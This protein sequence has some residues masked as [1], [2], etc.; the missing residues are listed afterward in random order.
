MGLPG[1]PDELAERIARY[2]H[3]AKGAYAKATEAALKSDT[4][5]W[6]QA[7]AEHGWAAL[8]AAPGHVAHWI[9]ELTGISPL[10]KEVVGP[11]L[12]RPKTI[13][14]YISSISHL[15]RAAGLPSPASTEVVRLALKR[16]RK[17]L[18]TRSRQTDPLTEVAI[19]K[20]IA[21]IRETERPSLLDLRDTALLLTMRDTVCRASEAVVLAWD[22]FLEDDD[23]GSG[24]VLIPFGKTDQEGQGDI[25]WVSPDAVAALRA[26]RDALDRELAALQAGEEDRFGALQ[27]VYERRL[28]VWQQLQAYQQAV[29][30][31]NSGSIDAR[32][33]RLPARPR[34]RPMKAAPEPPHR[35]EWAESPYIFRPLASYGWGQKLVTRDVINIISERCWTAGLIDKRYT[36]HS[37]RVGAVQDLAAAGMDLMA[38]MIQGGWK[39]AAMPARYAERLEAK[40]GAVARLRGRKR[41]EEE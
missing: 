28:A 6:I 2:A 19:D 22:E 10:T 27:A 20:V 29:R 12:K 8:P 41:I 13:G 18:K 11:P 14:R 21:S 9:D 17:T 4:A 24:T 7:C 35:I 5:I 32:L 16:M 25:R 34:G 31:R 26:W 38:I 33:A 37:T 39:S 23:D 1:L 36:A 40:R 15:H 3:D 30:A